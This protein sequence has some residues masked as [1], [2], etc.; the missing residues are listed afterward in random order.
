M[1]VQIILSSDPARDPSDAFVVGVV[2][3]MD[4]CLILFDHTQQRGYIGCSDRQF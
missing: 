1:K 4:K 2:G 3:R